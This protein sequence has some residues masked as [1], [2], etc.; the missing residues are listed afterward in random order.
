MAS[1]HLQGGFMR[2]LIIAEHD[3]SSLKDEFYKVLGGVKQLTPDID[4]LVAGF[5][6][7]AICE[8]LSGLSSIKKIL[9]IDNP[10][11]SQQSEDALAISIKDLANEYTHIFC[12][13][14]SFGKSVI[15]RLA[16]YLKVAAITGVSAI[17][18]A[19]TFVRP[20]YAGRLLTRVKSLDAI[21]IV[22]LLGS[23]FPLSDTSVH[24]CDVEVPVV[25]LE[26]NNIHVQ[27]Q[28]HF[29]SEKR[30]HSKRKPLQSAQVIV[31]AGRGL[32][33]KE[34]FD[35]LETLA[36]KLDAAVGA[37]RAVV[38]AGWLTNDKQIGQTAKIVAP[39]LYIA[40]GISGA[41]QHLAGM[42][43]SRIIIAINK[44]S[45]APIFQVANYG[46]VGDLSEVLPRLN[47]ML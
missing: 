2:I 15:P 47:A 19:D 35:E 39:E 24:R 3:G 42:K 37:T 23:A 33:S 8:Q 29:V 41:T 25:Y 4:V 26:N 27:P 10:V 34:N 17:E 22:T 45:N 20:I 43:D 32:G 28:T 30:N 6:C 44:D 1:E 46:L 14:S 40:L 7:T 12:S 36:D 21:K 5:R 16:A 38:D 31:S 9:L 18:S 13:T 11:F